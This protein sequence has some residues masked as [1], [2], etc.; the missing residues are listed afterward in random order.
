MLYLIININVL[1]V[2][3]DEKRNVL[4]G[5]IYTRKSLVSTCFNFIGSFWSNCEQTYRNL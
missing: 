5:K 3:V 1:N 4:M 2:Y